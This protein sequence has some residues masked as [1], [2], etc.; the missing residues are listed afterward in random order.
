[1]TGILTGNMGAESSKSP[2]DPLEFDRRGTETSLPEPDEPIIMLL[3]GRRRGGL[4]GDGLAAI[5]GEEGGEHLGVA[6]E[7]G[8]L[9]RRGRIVLE[10]AAAEDEVD[11]VGLHAARAPR[12]LRPQHRHRPAAQLHLQGAG[13][14]PDHANPLRRRRRRRR[15]GLVGR[16]RTD[17]GWG[18]WLGV[19][20][21]WCV[22]NRLQQPKG[23]TN[24]TGL[25]ME[26]TWHS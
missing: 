9:E 3:L 23:K 14:R 18:F 12:H 24:G 8:L 5:G 15:G 13:P 11:A 7:A 4:G 20:G 16:H 22:L 19:G 21:F 10:H 25:S 17:R 6:L 1:M 2:I 26:E